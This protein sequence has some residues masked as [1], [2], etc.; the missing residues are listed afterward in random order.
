MAV[1]SVLLVKRDIREQRRIR[2]LTAGGKLTHNDPA[3]VIRGLRFTHWKIE[4]NMA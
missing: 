4:K 2:F 1:Y 3:L